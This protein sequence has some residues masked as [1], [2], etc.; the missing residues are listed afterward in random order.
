M[1]K[2]KEEYTAPATDSL[3]ILRP[4]VP[5]A[6]ALAYINAVQRRYRFPQIK[7]PN[8]AE[9]IRP[10]LQDNKEKSCWKSGGTTMYDARAVREW[11]EYIAKRRALI[12]LGFDGWH[13]RR[14]YDLMELDSLVRGGTMDSEVDHPAFNITLMPE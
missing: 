6:E 14:P 9:N 2:I 3:P 7:R 11:A 1:K 12:V 5:E 4:G 8:W 10:I 13:D